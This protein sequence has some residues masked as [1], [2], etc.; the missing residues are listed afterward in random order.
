MSI[1]KQS[2]QQ[3]TISIHPFSKIR[4]HHVHQKGKRKIMADPNYKPKLTTDWIVCYEMKM[5][6]KEAKV[7]KTNSQHELTMSGSIPQKK[8]IL[9][10]PN[11]TSIK[12]NAY[13]RKFCWHFSFSFLLAG[14]RHWTSHVLWDLMWLVFL[15]PA[16]PD[17]MTPIR[18]KVNKWPT[19]YCT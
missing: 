9:S 15:F 6:Q 3:S 7:S 18:F 13:T 5:G 16:V 10:S 8:I 1:H 2:R 4:I 17:C 14:T 11:N 19:V 12:K